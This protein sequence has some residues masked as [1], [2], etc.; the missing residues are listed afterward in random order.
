MP[1]D[2][3]GP[4]TDAL[5][6][7]LQEIGRHST[8]SREEEAGLSRRYRDAG[9]RRALEALVT[10]NLRFVVAVAKGYR[11]RGLPLED[12]INEG[13]LG[14]MR[15]AARFDPRRGVRLVSYASWWIR[16]AIL[17][18]LA[19]TAGSGGAPPPRPGRE[20][21]APGR[22]RRAPR[23][24]PAP[25]SLQQ[26]G[27][28]GESGTALAERLADAT[29]APPDARL[30]RASL[31]RTLQAG[32]AFLPEREARV[33]RLFYGLEGGDAR[34]LERIGREMGVSRER[35]RQLKGRALSRLRESPRWAELESY[36]A[37]GRPPRGNPGGMKVDT[38]RGRG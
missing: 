17:A 3:R 21:G 4:G 12:L 8:L 5:D 23:R 20:T 10:A 27:G 31:R 1:K 2:A 29:A 6:L 35:V 37:R 18:A 15:A 30:Q 33:L 19:R 9:D 13:N 24:G 11:G 38:P 26:G 22:R 16:Q 7:Y 14:L 34:S 25:V 32:L 36:R 28:P